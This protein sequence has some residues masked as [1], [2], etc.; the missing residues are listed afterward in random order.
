MSPKQQKSIA[1]AITAAVLLIAFLVMSFTAIPERDLIVEQYDQ[2]NWTQFTPAPPPI[3]R[4]E[5]KTA[6]KEAAKKAPVV[7]KQTIKRVN[8][9]SL[10]NQLNLSE[11]NIQT[12]TT[13]PA[14]KRSKAS[15]ENIKIAKTNLASLSGNLNLSMSNTSSLTATPQRRR[16]KNSSGK[17]KLA[18]GSQN[19]AGSGLGSAGVSVGANLQGPTA[20]GKSIKTGI[21]NLQ[22]VGDLEGELDAYS[23]NYKG[24]VEWMRRNPVDLPPVAKRFMNYQRGDLTSRVAFSINNRAFDMMLLCVEATYEVRIVLMEK[25]DVT[26]LIDQGFHKKSNFL[27]VGKVDRLANQQIL[28]FSTNLKPAGSKKTTSFYQVFISWWESVKHEVE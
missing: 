11:I 23:P 6:P 17:V 2:I 16:G 24:L 18:A 22:E 26:Y 20:K 5:K 8:L 15:P 3:V 1:G 4:Q 25:R 12:K 19:G 14:G 28:K 13:A 21:I 9:Q 27:R 7:Q 10:Q